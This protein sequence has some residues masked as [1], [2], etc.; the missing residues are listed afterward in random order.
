MRYALFYKGERVKGATFSD[1]GKDQ[2]EIEKTL[3][4]GYTIKGI[5]EKEKSH[6]I[7]DILCWVVALVLIVLWIPL[8]P[9]FALISFILG[10]DACFGGD[11]DI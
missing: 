11:C 6:L 1:T 4:K 8:A 5:R 7:S 3:N 2:E 10:E 9:I